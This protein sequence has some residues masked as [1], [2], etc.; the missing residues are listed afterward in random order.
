MVTFMWKL[1]WHALVNILL[2]LIAVKSV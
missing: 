1:M 2:S